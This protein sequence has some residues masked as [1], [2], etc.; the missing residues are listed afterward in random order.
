MEEWLRKQSLA[1]ETPGL[2]GSNQTNMRAH[3]Q[4]LVLTLIRRFGPTAKADIARATGLSAQTVSVIMRELEAI[5]RNAYA[6]FCRYYDRRVL[7]E[8]LLATYE[9]LLQPDYVAYP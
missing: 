1:T 7:A 9:E 8:N 6:T 4:R 2:V 5:G 3:N